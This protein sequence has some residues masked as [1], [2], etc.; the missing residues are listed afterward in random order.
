MQNIVKCKINK[1][2]KIYKIY[3][4]SLVYLNQMMKNYKY[5]QIDYSKY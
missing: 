2:Y 5:I 3:Y 4:N 1:T